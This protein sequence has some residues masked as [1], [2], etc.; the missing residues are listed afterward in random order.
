MSI[1]Y[2]AFSAD[3]GATRSAPARV[4]G[5]GI[6]AEWGPDLA[7]DLARRVLCVFY[8]ESGDPATSFCGDMYS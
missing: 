6:P 2:V 5:N 3:A 7:T 4:A 1:F 8:A